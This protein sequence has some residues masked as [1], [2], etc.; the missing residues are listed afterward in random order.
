MRHELAHVGAN[1]LAQT[2]QALRQSVQRLSAEPLQ[3]AR[4]TALENHA[5]IAAEPMTLT[6]LAYWQQRLFATG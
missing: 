3:R 6:Q 2:Q 1:E 4:E 5:I